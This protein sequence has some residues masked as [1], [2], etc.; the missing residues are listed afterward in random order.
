LVRTL[1]WYLAN[2][3]WCEEVT[4]RACGRERLGLG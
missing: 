3:A 4:Q 2:R 1:D